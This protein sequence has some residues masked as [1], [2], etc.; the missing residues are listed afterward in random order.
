MVSLFWQQHQWMDAIVWK[1]VRVCVFCL[2]VCIMKLDRRG[3]DL[4]Y[5]SAGLSGCCS[6]DQ[7]ISTGDTWSNWHTE[8]PRTLSCR[9]SFPW[10]PPRRATRLTA[11]G[12][13][14]PTGHSTDR[15]CRFGAIQWECQTQTPANTQTA[16]AVVHNMIW[17]QCNVTWSCLVFENTHRGLNLLRCNDAIN[18]YV[19]GDVKQEV[20][21]HGSQDIC[22]SVLG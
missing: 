3:L 6:F 12:R 1:W 8:M 17:I 21:L 10:R 13:S 18:D 5:F 7:N 11:A 22:P 16:T 9:T 19:L 14:A 15:C 20:L 4:E 2:W